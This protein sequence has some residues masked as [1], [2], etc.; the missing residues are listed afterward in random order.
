MF[1]SKKKQAPSMPAHNQPVDTLISQH[2][3]IEGNL[4]TENS[5]KLDGR[6]HGNLLAKGHVIVGESGL[7]QGDLHTT[8][9]LVFGRIEGNIRAQSVQLK[10]TAH[11]LGNIETE[12]FQVEPGA[13]YQG[14][15]SMGK[16]DVL[17]ALP[18][19]SGETA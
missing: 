16:A 2:C 1:G 13:Y 14:G 8:D 12:I 18:D 15:V 3:V 7:I 19:G 6:V 9:L 17:P 5:I 11:I 4:V 10:P